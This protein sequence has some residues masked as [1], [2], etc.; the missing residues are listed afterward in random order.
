MQDEKIEEVALLHK[1]VKI[2]ENEDYPLLPLPIKITEKTIEKAKAQGTYL[3]IPPSLLATLSSKVLK[4][5][6]EEN[7]LKEEEEKKKKKRKKHFSSTIEVSSSTLKALSKF[8]NIPRPLF[9][10]N[11]YSILGFKE[12]EPSSEELAQAIQLALEKLEPL[13]AKKIEDSRECVDLLQELEKIIQT[14]KRKEK[15]DHYLKAKLENLEEIDGKEEVESPP[16]EEKPEKKEE[17]A[18]ATLEKKTE[19]KKEESE[20]EP[21]E[22]KEDQEQKKR[23]SPLK[24]KEKKKGKK[25]KPQS[26][27]KGG[28]PKKGG[29]VSPKKPKK[30][31]EKKSSKVL[32]SFIPVVF[33]L[34]FLVFA[35][36]QNWFT[37]SEVSPWEEYGALLKQ[38]ESQGGVEN[39]TNPLVYVD[40][41]F[42]L[43]QWCEEQGAEDKRFPERVNYH[44]K[45]IVTFLASRPDLVSKEE[46]KFARYSRAWKLF[47]YQ[48]DPESN[49]WK[50]P[51]EQKTPQ[52]K[53][54][55]EKS[56]S[57][58]RKILGEELS[59]KSSEHFEVFCQEGGWFSAKIYLEQFVPRMEDV[60]QEIVR[61]HEEVKD[62]KNKLKIMIFGDHESYKDYARRHRREAED[63]PGIYFP[64][65]SMLILFRARVEYN[66]DAFS[67]EDLFHHGNFYEMVLSKNS[68]PP[69]VITN[70]EISA[71][72]VLGEDIEKYRTQHYFIA[73]QRSTKYNARDKAVKAGKAFEEMYRNFFLVMREHFPELPDINRL[74]PYLIF[75]DR[76]GYLAYRRKGKDKTADVSAGHY[77]PSKRRMITFE[78]GDGDWANEIIFHEG[79]HQL[80]DFVSNYKSSSMMWFS[81]GMSDY[82]AGFKLLPDGSYR[83]GEVNDGRLQEYVMY[84]TRAEHLLLTTADLLDF[85]YSR[86]EAIFQD[87]KLSEEM[88]NFRFSQVYFQ[89]WVMTYYFFKGPNEQHRQ[90]YMKYLRFEIEGKAGLEKVKEVFGDLD[91]QKLDKNIKDFALDLYKKG[92]KK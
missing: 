80:M 46:D 81:E 36:Q 34:V 27:T 84:L 15:Y 87:R 59:S 92:H 79:T 14:P 12:F 35:F 6:E 38:L 4:E 52:P 28:S 63:E 89:S 55:T 76:E 24:E 83:V 85:T 48:F 56:E 40:N 11:L 37:S 19:S 30:K 53:N 9:S 43:G 18:S 88:K 32:F 47:S 64:D 51:E 57:F 72:E 13:K 50:S 78:Q 70:A 42:Q 23:T 61:L 3:Q 49:L 1:E 20:K 91:L 86:R 54:L 67:N 41:H 74:M 71:T 68:G 62:R 5:E 8:L 16:K 73:V 44:Y 25:E 77:E 75:K 90:R 2:E 10:E 82:I 58:A 65:D 33:L 21:K 22:E 26:P 45:I 39:Y 60:Y 17:S 69:I 29:G 7:S 66:K 31:G